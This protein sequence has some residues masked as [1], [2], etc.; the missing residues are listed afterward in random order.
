[1]ATEWGPAVAAASRR[2]PTGSKRHPERARFAYSTNKKIIIIRSLA[3]LRIVRI[4]INDD[5]NKNNSNNND[6]NDNNN[7]NRLLQNRMHSSE[8]R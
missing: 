4:T 6:D 5:N 2:S 1:M 7:N 3:A 8:G